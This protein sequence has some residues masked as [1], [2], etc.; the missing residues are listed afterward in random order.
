[1]RYRL[2]LDVGTSSLGWA[3]LEIDANNKPV[4]LL[5]LGVRI[6]S[7]GRN[8]KDKTSLAAKRRVARGMRRQRDRRLK[9]RNRLMAQLIELGL[10]PQ[11]E[12]ER[13]DLEHLDPYE[14]RARAVDKKESLL[15]Y[16]LGRAL[17]HLNQRRGFKSNR[18]TNGT[19]DED[20]GVTRAAIAE[21]DRRLEQSPSLTLGGYLHNSRKRNKSVRARPDLGIYPERRHYEHEF[22]QIKAVQRTRQK[23]TDEDWTRLED[24][25]F[26]QR[27]LRP[28]MPGRCR[29]EPSEYRAAKALPSAQRFRILQEAGNLRIVPQTGTARALPKATLEKII[30]RLGRQR[31]LS[32][33]QIAKL[34][35]LEGGERLNLDDGKRAALKGDETAAA[36]IKAGWPSDHWAN[37]LLFERDRIVELLLDA[38]DE[39]D[40]I[41]RLCR[42]WDLGYEAAT[43]IARVR[44]PDGHG[45]VSLKAIGLLLP[46]IESGIPYHEAAKMAYGHHSFFEDGEILP[47]LPY[48]GERLPTSVIGETTPDGATDEARYGRFPNPTV[49]IGL[50][51]IRRLINHLIQVYGHPREIV[52][53][54]GRE[55][56]QTLEQKNE[57]QRRQKEGQDRNDK[58]RDGIEKHGGVPTPGLMRR[59]R[60]WEEQG[61]PQARVC[62][63]S[64]EPISF[65]MVVRG[66]DIDVDHILPFSATLD[67]SMANKVVCKRAMNRR[68]GNQSPARAFNGDE[69]EAIQMRT[70]KW[71]ANKSWRFR[72]DAMER[73][74]HTRGFL[75][76]QLN[77]T[78]YLARAAKNYLTA[79]CP[80]NSVWVLPGH[81]T[82]L[83]RARW[84]FNTL[85]G[86]SNRKERTDHRHHAI[87]A[88]V[89]ALTDRALLQQIARASARDEIS[90]VMDAVPESPPTIPSLRD[91][92]REKLEALIVFHKPDHFRPASDGSTTGALHNDTAY[93]LAQPDDG[94]GKQLVRVRKSL[95]DLA[96]E[97]LQTLLADRALAARIT[98]DWSRA[99]A[100]GATWKDYAAALAK[101][102]KTRGGGLPKSGVRNVRIIERMSSS[103]L[104]QVSNGAGRPYKAYKTDGNEFMEIFEDSKG[105]WRGETIRRVDANQPAFRPVWR[106]SVKTAR[107][108]MRLHVNDLVA[109]GDG[110]SRNTFRVVQ[111]S[112]QRLV[113]ALHS[114]AGALKKRN[115]DQEDP[116]KYLQKSAGAAKAA[117]MRRLKVSD[118]GQV[119]DPG[120]PV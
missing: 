109:L 42:E 94:N 88:V 83:L 96:P 104:F 87:D 115:S 76:R 119:Y 49:H 13:K 3:I 84:G 35:H 79:I 118:L 29:F 62:P 98:A 58:Y 7:D 107:L 78:R 45:S 32:F 92:L 1:M 52:V 34:A 33:K 38:E 105:K 21:L 95:I 27:A 60:L 31:T 10:M 8:P 103:S 51:Q 20:A 85:L 23:L 6:Y 40:L 110:G 53:E 43:S 112:G 18:K 75:D 89:Q 91:H 15:P 63:Y 36:I 69:F 41:D 17:F 72:S 9:R 82:S 65:E 4:Q 113:L 5:D 48:Y 108:V 81:M 101:P 47:T 50:N 11:S 114:E 2:G 57:T 25:I 39:G 26:F 66:D 73:F 67:D 93:G 16:E 46:R 70:A 106:D 77:E 100:V 55:M 24:T 111:I 102:D 28:V 44:L 56:K 61:P 37:M 74:E 71:P 64:G 86:S 80:A 99:S 22:H 59:I 54:L 30:E 117:G 68:K 19:A 12:P 97:K 14:L 120:P 116:F 90:R